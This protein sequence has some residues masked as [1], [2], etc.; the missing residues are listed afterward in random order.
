MSRHSKWSTIK[1]KKGVL[2]AKRG[3][4]FTKMAKLVTVAAKQGGGDPETNFK[5]RLAIDKARSVNTPADNIERAI[6]KGTG[7]STEDSQ[8]EELVYEA[9][10][11][12]GVAL[13][14]EVVTDNKNRTLPEIKTILSD[15]GGRLGEAGSVQWMFKKQGV[16]SID[17]PDKNKKEIAELT[18]IEAGADDIQ[19]ENNSLAIY[20]KSNQL[21]AIKI[22]LEEAGL[23]IDS[24]DL[25]LLPTNPV[26]IEDKSELEKIEKLMEALDEQE[27]INEVYSNLID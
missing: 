10:G 17:K 20:T 5:L 6:K 7:E 21:T 3:Q 27:D 24:A 23:T 13:I 9:Y 18:A 26:K 11:P 15:H 19:E 22:A 2:D 8:L 4:I 16:I 1:R 14:I 12:G 25:E